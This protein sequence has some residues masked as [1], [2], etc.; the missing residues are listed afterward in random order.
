MSGEPGGGGVNPDQANVTAPSDV[1]VHESDKD[2]TVPD[3][4]GRLTDRTPK[5]MSY[6]RASFPPSTR[7]SERSSFTTS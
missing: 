6:A 5:H 2:G 7:R 4:A 3:S 1:P